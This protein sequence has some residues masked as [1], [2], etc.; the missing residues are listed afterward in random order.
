[1]NMLDFILAASR[2]TI[3]KSEFGQKMHDTTITKS[4]FGQ[5]MHDTTISEDEK[6]KIL[7]EVVMAGGYDNLED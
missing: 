1:M 3:T 4:E 7:E 5:K 2:Q 6:L